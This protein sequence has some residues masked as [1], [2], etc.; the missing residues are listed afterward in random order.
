MNKLDRLFN[1]RLSSHSIT[2]SS[3]AWEQIE[4]G[5]SKKNSPLQWMRWAAI[6]VPATL[7]GLLLLNKPEPALVAEMPKP[8]AQTISEI[9]QPTNSTQPVETSKFKERKTQQVAHFKKAKAST[10]TQTNTGSTFI[11]TSPV[12]IVTPL[13]EVTFEPALVAP[14]VASEEIKPIVLVYTLESVPA[15]ALSSAEEKR[16]SSL[17]RVVEFAKTVKHSDPIGDLRGM[18]DELLAINLRKKIT[19]KN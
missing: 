13:T 9:K 10:D 14:V 18:K 19:K 11:T 4:A 8:A 1:E 17:E 16:G 5:L 6:L 2:P 7:L 15:N 12:E 3:V